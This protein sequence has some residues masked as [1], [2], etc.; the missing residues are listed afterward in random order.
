M[1]EEDMNCVKADASRILVE[2]SEEGD[3]CSFCMKEIG[4][5]D[6]LLGVDEEYE[7]A[8]AVLTHFRSMEDF[9]Q[10]CHPTPQTS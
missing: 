6:W 1:Y 5:R 10:R 8:R 3:L 2:A 9:S 4:V 7:L